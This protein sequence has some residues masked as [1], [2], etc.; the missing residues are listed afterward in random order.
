M[1]NIFKLLVESYAS[2]TVLMYYT[3]TFNVYIPSV[4]HDADPMYLVYFSNHEGWG[5][6]TL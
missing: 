4:T 3:K 5:F 1:T 6:D 2:T